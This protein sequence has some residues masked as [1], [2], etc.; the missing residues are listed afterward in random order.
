[1]DLLV[2]MRDHRSLILDLP[3]GSTEL[4]DLLWVGMAHPVTFMILLVEALVVMDW[5]PNG[6]DHPLTVMERSTRS[7]DISLTRAMII[8]VKILS[9]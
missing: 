3:A 9:M 4:M 5:V 2:M 1:M 6:S 8:Q 7:G